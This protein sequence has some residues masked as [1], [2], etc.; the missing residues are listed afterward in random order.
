M[1]CRRQIR[2]EVTGESWLT[3]SQGTLVVEK[4]LSLLAKIKKFRKLQLVY[5]PGAVHALAL[6][7]AMQDSETSL[8]K[9]ENIKLW[10]PSDLPTSERI[11]GCKP[12]LPDMEVRL[13][14]AQCS[15]ALDKL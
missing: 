6:E 10:M 5:M 13:R 8:P 15:D 7:E 2:I 11:E 1:F 14:E 12:E 4:R 9:A 3:A